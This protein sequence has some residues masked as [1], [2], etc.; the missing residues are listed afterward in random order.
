MI[1]ALIVDDEA[2]ARERIRTLLAGRENVTV[3]GECAG[4]PQAVAAIEAEAPD[5]VFLDVQMPDLDGFGVLEVLGP[6]RL[7]AVVFVTAYDEYALRAFEVHALDYLLKPIEPGRFAAAVDHAVEA[8]GERR[9]PESDQRLRDLLD[10]LGERARGEDRLVVRS[11]GRIFFLLPADIDWVEADGKY[12]RLHVG[13]E[14]HVV[15]H[16]LK[17]LAVRLKRHGFVRVHRSAIVNAERIR[18]LQPWFHGEFVVILKDGTRITS[19]AAHSEDL[20]RMVDKT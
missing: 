17:Q 4:G 15:R 9:R 8:L 19:S 3:V 2:L 13:K 16:P 1:R 11:E 12:A 20:H 6:E 18:E 10:A 5:L 7:P 14:I